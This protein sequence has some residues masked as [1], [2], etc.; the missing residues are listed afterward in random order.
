[1][2][3]NLEKYSIHE[4]INEIVSSVR[5]N[6]NLKVPINTRFDEDVE[7]NIDKTRI[8]QVLRNILDNCIKFA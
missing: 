6:P 7:L 3:S 4:I 1:M 2:C 5:F 8:K